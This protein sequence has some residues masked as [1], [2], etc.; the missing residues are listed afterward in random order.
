VLRIGLVGCGFIGNVHSWALW[1]LRKTG[2]VD[3]QVV[4]TCDA[5]PERAVTLA[6]P[7]D[8]EVCDLDA[9]LDRVDVVYVCTPTAQHLAVVES[10]ARRGLAV[11]C[12]KP[13]A[14]DLEQATRVAEVLRGVPHQVGLVLRAAPVFEAIRT[15]LAEGTY[16]RP[17][18]VSLRDDQFFP[19][20]GHYGSTWRAEH[21]TAGGGTLIEHSIHDIDVLRWLL[22]DPV[23]VSCRTSSFFE[24]SGIEDSASATLSFEDGLVANLLSVW[25]QIL[26]RPSTRR[27]EVFCEEAFLWT[28]DDNTGPLHV[29]TTQ[30][31]EELMCPLPE[32]TRSIPV[33]EEHRDSLGLYAEASRRFLTD[34]QTK[35]P[36]ADDAL[37]AHRI[38]DACY[39]SAGRS[40][41]AV[42]I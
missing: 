1:A 8:A 32:W 20:Q 39:V 12:E 7:H 16:G 22:G 33:P 14:T 24:Y 3:L 23:D 6:K 28:E 42:R 36:D 9:L 4:A 27:L 34:L 31:A 17:M 11:F 38:V 26:S 29:E 40:G 5:D 41:E 15:K 37:A 10:A 25:H 13:L 30:G 19:I 18:A 2:T 21:A 35:A